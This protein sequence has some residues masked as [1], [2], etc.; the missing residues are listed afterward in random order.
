[1]ACTFS[2]AEAESVA[3]L[4]V[5]RLFIDILRK[6]PSLPPKRELEGVMP[7]DSG[8]TESR[9]LTKLILRPYDEPMLEETDDVMGG[10]T[11]N[12][13]LTLEDE[14]LPDDRRLSNE[15][16]DRIF[17]TVRPANDGWGSASSSSDVSRDMRGASELR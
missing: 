9:L 13:A 14:P 15:P 6:K 3:A 11:T 16:A 17:R 4:S 7:V 12:V 8:T 5:L 10:E 1:M 2:L